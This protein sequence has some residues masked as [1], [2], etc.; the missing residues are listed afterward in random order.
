MLFTDLNYIGS[1]RPERECSGADVLVPEQ[2]YFQQTQ[3]DT[4]ANSFPRPATHNA[5]IV[6]KHEGTRDAKDTFIVVRTLGIILGVFAGRDCS[7]N[8]RDSIRPI[9]PN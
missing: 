7:H 2:F 9:V 1:R 6:S 8:K 4:N 5:I 3:N